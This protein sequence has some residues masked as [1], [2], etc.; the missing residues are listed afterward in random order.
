[1]NCLLKGVVSNPVLPF[2]TVTNHSSVLSERE[3]QIEQGKEILRV[4]RDWKASGNPFQAL[5]L[6]C[7]LYVPARSCLVLSLGA[8]HLGTSALPLTVLEAVGWEKLR[9]LVWTLARACQRNGKGLP[10]NFPSYWLMIQKP[11]PKER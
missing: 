7:G 6:L 5:F 10:N 8:E 2:S 1:M 3:R 9:S 11:P 4:L